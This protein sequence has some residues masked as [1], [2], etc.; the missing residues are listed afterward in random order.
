MGHFNSTAFVSTPKRSLLIRD[1][2]LM[3]KKMGGSTHRQMSTQASLNRHK[4]WKARKTKCGA[5]LQR[6][7]DEP[8]LCWVLGGGRWKT[9]GLL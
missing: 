6:K 9:V 8:E 2:R 7:H 1:C 4:Q 5:V 3:H